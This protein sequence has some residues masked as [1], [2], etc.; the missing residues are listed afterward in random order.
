M[1]FIIIFSALTVLSLIF[2]FIVYRVAFYNGKHAD[3]THKVLSGRDY[4]PY[5]DE[6]INIIDKALEIP[7]EEVYTYSYDKKKL[8]GRL[9]IKDE[10]APFHIQFNGYKGNGIRDFSGGL[11][12]ALA[13]GANVLLTDQRAHGKSEG[14]NITFGVKERYDVYSWIGYIHSR[15]KGA[16]IYLEGISMGAATVLMS[17][18]LG[19]A[20]KNVRG[21]IADCPY[22]TPF[23]IV[24]LVA[25]RETK[26]KYITYPFIFLGALLFAH[27]NIFSASPLKAVK[28]TSVPILIIHGTTD[29]YVPFEMSEKIYEQNKEK[30]TLVPVEGAPHGLSFIKDGKTYTAAFNEFLQKTI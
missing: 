1:P 21:V 27:F 10:K 24:S 29:S 2:S 11:Q 22:S 14:I 6:M 28:N 15:F 12:L 4:D 25:D 17:T 19:L 13:A 5:H 18:D 16:P 7:F 20:E 3:V 9:Y 26:L 8:Y 30:I 23:G